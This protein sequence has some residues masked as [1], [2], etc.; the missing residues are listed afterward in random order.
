MPSASTKLNSQAEVIDFE[1]A[2]AARLDH[3]G[4]DSADEAT[5]G[6]GWFERRVLR[7]AELAHHLRISVR[8]LERY[9]HDPDDPLPV[10][11]GK[12]YRVDTESPKVIDWLRRYGV[13][14][15]MGTPNV[16]RSER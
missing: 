5:Q 3:G 15:Q 14:V 6:G 9:V 4:V 10:L 11:R 12:P 16:D 8:T 7:L 2:T 13:P 1:G